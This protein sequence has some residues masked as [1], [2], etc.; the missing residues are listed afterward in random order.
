M[1]THL[2]GIFSILKKLKPGGMLVISVL[3]KASY[4]VLDELLLAFAAKEVITSPILLSCQKLQKVKV[5]FL[6]SDL[7]PFGLFLALFN[8]IA[9]RKPFSNTGSSN[10]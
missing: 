2:T 5:L 9:F 1:W 10:P 8:V 7:L 4:M 6:K 3:P